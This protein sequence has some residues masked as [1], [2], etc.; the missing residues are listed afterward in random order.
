M[1][2]MMVEGATGKLG[3]I[4]H[5]LTLRS[6]DLGMEGLEIIWTVSSETFTGGYPN[7]IGPIVRKRTNLVNN[8][9]GVF[10]S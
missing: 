10:V 9:S 8:M 5:E 6:S 4:A 7:S 3:N 1:V 2:E